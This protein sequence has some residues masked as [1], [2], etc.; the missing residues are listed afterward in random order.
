MLAR[1][2]FIKESLN[3]NQLSR[4]ELKVLEDFLGESVNAQEM[5]LSEQGK[6]ET[7]SWRDT[8]DSE[9][10][11]KDSDYKLVTPSGIFKIDDNNNYIVDLEKF[12]ST[13]PQLEFSIK[14]V[15]KSVGA[16]H[17]DMI[18]EMNKIAEKIDEAKN[19]FEKVVEF[20]QKCDIHVPNLGL[21]SINKLAFAID[22]CT[23]ALQGLLYKGWRIIAVCPQPDQRRPDYI[24][25]MHVPD[26]NDSVVVEHFV[27]EGREGD[28]KDSD[29]KKKD[30]FAL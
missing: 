21:M 19:R 4:E 14:G 7:L 11:K 10:V 27:G 5:K 28:L 23:E 20:N 9:I 25:G 15:P 12:T 8:F 1:I 3:S 13:F 29:M 6:P 18:T 2:K 24:L 17:S 22:Y 16:D 26:I 30:S